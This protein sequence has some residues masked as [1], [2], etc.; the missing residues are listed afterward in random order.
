MLLAVETV[1][2]GLLHQKVFYHAL[3]L[4]LLH[5]PRVGLPHVHVVAGKYQLNYYIKLYTVCPY[6]HVIIIAVG[7]KRNEWKVTI[8]STTRLSTFKKKGLVL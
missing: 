2:A 5:G 8:V 4:G 6:T 3:V 7:T 1:V